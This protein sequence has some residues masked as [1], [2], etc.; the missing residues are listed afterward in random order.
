M[1][2]DTRVIIPIKKL[3]DS[4]T[5]FSHKFTL[6]QREELTIS[7]LNDMLKTIE[8]VDEVDPLVITP[9]E[10]VEEL[11]EQRDI[12]NMKEPD[13]GL[14][15]S[16]EMAID[17]SI[18]SGYD[19]V[20]ILPGDLPLIKQEDIEE[21]LDSGKGSQGVVLTP[22]KENGTNALFLKPPDIINLGFGGESFFDHVREATEQ[23]ITPRLYRSESL[24]RDMDKP[25]D[26]AKVEA[27]GEGTETHNF[28]RKFKR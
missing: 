26:L 4:K 28:L 18:E 2:S 13:I 16:L 19:S 5:S 25:E 1:S 6:E 21:I 20:L 8:E 27:I 15:G 14:N 22:S 12:P 9:D 10:R 11:M 23:N 7:M 3:E 24:E 17:D